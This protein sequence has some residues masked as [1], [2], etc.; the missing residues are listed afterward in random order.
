MKFREIISLYEA[1]HHIVRLDSE[2]V[3]NFSVKTR[4]AL[5]KN[6]KSIKESYD[7]YLD[8]R[9]SLMKETNPTILED[10]D[11]NSVVSL[12]DNNG[13]EFI[14]KLNE[15]L[16]TDQE[17]SLIYMTYEE[18]LNEDNDIPLVVLDKLSPFIQEN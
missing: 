15:L 6:Y 17:L 8:M 9:N 16:N 7:I 1:L 5:L 14:N 10:E 11:K 13:K 2:K 12:E 4:L 3:F 18:I